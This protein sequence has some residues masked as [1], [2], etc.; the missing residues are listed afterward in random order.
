MGMVGLMTMISTYFVWFVSTKGDGE[1]MQPSSWSGA[2]EYGM[3]SITVA[4]VGFIGIL[5]IWLFVK[6]RSNVSQ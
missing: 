4:A 6:T 3:G 1:L 5:Y 2:D